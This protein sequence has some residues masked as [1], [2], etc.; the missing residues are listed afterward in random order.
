MVGN[1]LTTVTRC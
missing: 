1:K